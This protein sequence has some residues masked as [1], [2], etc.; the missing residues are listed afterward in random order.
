MKTLTIIPASWQHVLHAKRALLFS[1]QIQNR[2]DT[3]VSLRHS[4]LE[5]NV[6]LLKGEGA[7]LRT[8]QRH[9]L[10]CLPS[11]SLMCP[12]WPLR[13]LGTFNSGL[14]STRPFYLTRQTSVWSLVPQGRLRPSLISGTLGTCQLLSKSWA[15]LPHVP[16]SQSC[17]LTL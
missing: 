11:L 13:P 17:P 6:I 2:V 16:A 5:V 8:S 14:S 15:H 4:D 7:L 9:P 10:P 3:V 12:L 1:L